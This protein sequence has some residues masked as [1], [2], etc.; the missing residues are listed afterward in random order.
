MDCKKIKFLLPDY[1]SGNIPENNKDEI[2][3]HLQVCNTCKKD[4][5]EISEILNTLGSEK[6]QHPSDSYWINLVPNIHNRLKE[7]SSTFPE[8]LIKF[9]SI[10]LLAAVIAIIIIVRIFN[11]PLE[12]FETGYAEK[13]NLNEIVKELDYN[14]YGLLNLNSDFPVDGNSFD[15][16]AIKEILA[17]TENENT[18][19]ININITINTL[20]DREVN[21]LITLL[22]EN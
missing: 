18:D 13:T 11:Y 20:N 12:N 1:I 16:F 15:K 3:N 8:K 4:Y 6:L 22:D 17:L 7:K 5:I 2:V 21:K 14:D 9:A 10:P 19:L